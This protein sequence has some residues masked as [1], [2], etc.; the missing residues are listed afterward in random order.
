MTESSGSLMDLAPKG[1][2][3]DEKW[4]Q[5]PPLPP[6]FIFFLSFKLEDIS[7]FPVR[8]QQ[9]VLVPTHIFRPGNTGTAE[10][11]GGT[12]CSFSTKTWG[13]WTKGKKDTQYPKSLSQGH[14]V[15]NSPSSPPPVP[16][17]PPPLPPFLLS[18]LL[19]FFNQAVWGCQ[20]FWDED[21][22]PCEK[23]IPC[24]PSSP[25]RSSPWEHWWWLAGRWWWAGGGGKE[26]GW[27]DGGMKGGMNTGPPW[28][29]DLVVQILSDPSLTLKPTPELRAL[30][31]SC[32]LPPTLILHVL[33]PTVFLSIHSLNPQLQDLLMRF[34]AWPTD[35][36]N[37]EQRGFAEWRASWVDSEGWQW[38]TKER[39]LL[40]HCAQN[41]PGTATTTP[42]PTHP[43][44]HLAI[45]VPL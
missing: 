44:S 39:V 22:Q 7:R 42:H 4:N 31:C 26:E 3:A 2:K 17:T 14:H 41:L 32:P 8:S 45:T 15:K 25:W 11:T 30:L 18:S 29:T 6:W 20:V 23:L 40:L 5:K 1:Q 24:G 13:L 35:G 9:C 16:S 37:R 12:I 34:P 33:L 27:M 43:P 21:S 38:F 36:W 28:P 19:F 10:R